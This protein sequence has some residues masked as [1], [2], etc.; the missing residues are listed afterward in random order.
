LEELN[1]RS[2]FIDFLLGLSSLAGA[3]LLWF[4][5]CL[6]SPLLSQKNSSH[7]LQPFLLIAQAHRYHNISVDAIQLPTLIFNP[8]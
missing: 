4:Q 6:T 1:Q 8:F 2:L 7:C 5:F 3:A